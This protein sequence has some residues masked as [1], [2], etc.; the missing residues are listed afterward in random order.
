MKKWLFNLSCIALLFALTTSSKPVDYY[1]ITVKVNNIRHDYGT[2]QLQVYRS[3]E[4]FKNET[5]W[6]VRL[7]KKTDVK[8]NCM[9]CVITGIPPG[10]YGVALLDDENSDTKMNYSF[11]LPKEGFGFSDYFHTAWSKPKFESFKFSL[12]ADK[13]VSIKV[14]YV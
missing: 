4:A 5:A 11:L 1:S 7:F 2:I 8:N 10:E 13:Q 9:T 3:A 12:S 6:K 14:R